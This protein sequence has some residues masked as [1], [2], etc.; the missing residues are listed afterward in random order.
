[1]V[2]YAPD[3]W[4]YC[5]QMAQGMSQPSLMFKATLANGQPVTA[6]DVEVHLYAACN[7][8]DPSVC[9][10]AELAGNGSYPLV[11]STRLSASGLES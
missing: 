9:E 2:F 8:K 11:Y 4:Y 5:H 3:F 6:Y 10:F 7:E 1:M